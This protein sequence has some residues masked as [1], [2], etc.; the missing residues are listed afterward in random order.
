MPTDPLKRYPEERRLATVLFADVQGFTALAEQ[1]DFETVSDMIKDISK[2]LDKAIEAHNGYIDKHLGD[3]VMGVWGAPFAGDNDA[4]EA[5]SAG[6]DLV[7]AVAEFCKKTSIPG[8]DTLKLRVGINTGLVFAGYIGT[9]NEYT[10]IGDTV[11]LASRL[12]QIAEPGGVAIGENTLRMVRGSFR[13]RRLEP[14]K[15]KGKAELIQPYSVEGHLTTPG[16]IQYQSADSLVTNMV[17]RDDE[18]QKLQEQYNRAFENGRA[19]MALLSGDIGIGKSRLLMEFTNRLEE[20]ADKVSVLSTRGLAQAAR[21]PFYLWRVLLRNRFGVRD[22]DPSQTANEKWSKGVESIWEKGE[23]KTKMDATKI[24]GA[25]IGLM[26]EDSPASEERFQRVYYLVRE[27]MRRLASRKQLVL[28]FDDLQWADRESLQL[29]SNLLNDE[30][31]PVPLL[32]LGAARTEFLKNQAH[33]HNLSRVILLNPLPL[34][35]EVVANAYPDLR[36]LP[37]RVLQEIATRAE[38]NPYFMEEIV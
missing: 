29:L 19:S 20:K 25:M 1:L 4:Q 27:L 32:V 28:I 5:V 16:R 9:R 31:S 3:G 38:G 12:E 30:V 2:R 11:N 37:E 35:A 18:I 21:I 8:A 7:R 23:E 15:V 22:E 10:V 6:L 26:A 33:W 24:V 13:I 14:T 34:E 17:G 36:V